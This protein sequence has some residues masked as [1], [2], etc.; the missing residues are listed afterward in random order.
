VDQYAPESFLEVLF[1]KIQVDVIKV[2]LGEFFE[3]WVGLPVERLY[4]IIKCILRSSS[5]SQLSFEQSNI[6]FARIAV[7][8]KLASE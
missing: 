6:L 1:D 4:G 7:E 2:G 3:Q 8:P 5:G